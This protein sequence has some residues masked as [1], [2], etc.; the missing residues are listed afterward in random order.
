MKTIILTTTLLISVGSFSFA[1]QRTPTT[2]ALELSR[3]ESQREP[4]GIVVPFLGAAGGYTGYENVNSVE[5]TPA[6]LKLLGSWYL[7]SPVVFDLGYGVNNQQFTQAGPTQDTSK[8]GGILEFAARYRWDNRWQAGVIANQLYE[9]GAALSAD[10]GDA[11]F[12]GLQA[13]K[14]FNISP[15]WLARV[16]A[17]AMALTN[18]TDG[19]VMMY[20]I[21]LQLGWNPGAYRTSVRQTAAQENPVQRE[22]MSETMG[23]EDVSSDLSATATAPSRPV[24]AVEPGSALE[25]VALSDLVSNDKNIQFQTA[26]ANLSSQDREKLS[27][28]A[29]A[30]S[31]NKDLFDR[32]E[33]RGY[34]DSSGPEAFNQQLSQ[35]RADQVR[36]VLRQNGLSDSQIVAVGRGTEDSTGVMDEDRRAELVFIGVKDEAKL[37]D[38]LSNIE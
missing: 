34:A 2:S 3:E 24:A 11:H 4:R 38:A 27:R 28:V 7:E 10:Q 18:N 20:L 32:V 15:A 30:L 13:L 19:Q 8:T 37:R 36:N 14:E 6:T 23:T 5:G 35:E 21:D 26:Q 25:G 12:V 16:G 33:V 17:R 22:P 31:D 9:Q 29:Q 1:N